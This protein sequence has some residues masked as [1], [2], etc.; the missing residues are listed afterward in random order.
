MIFEKLNGRNK[1]HTVPLDVVW[2]YDGLL[3]KLVFVIIVIT[4][5][6]GISGIVMRVSSSL[7]L[8]Y[9]GILNI[10]LSLAIWC[11]FMPFFL[12][13]KIKMGDIKS[14][15]GILGLPV[16]ALFLY[17][18]GYNLLL[19]QVLDL[20]KFITSQ[21]AYVEGY[22]E[23]I[24]DNVVHSK[25]NTTTY[26][27]FTVNNMNFSVVSNSIG[28]IDWRKKQRVSYLPHNKNVMNIEPIE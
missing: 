8:N 12:I 2:Y 18:I 23:K 1:K 4:M 6:I 28:Y 3:V 5:I 25:G 13:C 7:K 11:L 20:P 27:R 21:Y 19:P 14:Y 16:S 10:G 24:Y 22:P 26:K 9:L 15:W 17:F